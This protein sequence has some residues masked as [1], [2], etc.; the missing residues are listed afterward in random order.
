MVRMTEQ[1]VGVVP[2]FTI[3]DRL[4]KAR[5]LTGLDQ[6]QFALAL[7]VSR[8]TVSNYEGGAT[9]HLKP[10]VLKQWALY[11]GVSLE[12]IETGITSE[13]TG[14]DGDGGADDRVRT[15]NHLLAMRRVQRD[16]R[17]LSDVADAA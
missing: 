7:G 2:E 4:R 12:W 14:P 13:P 1:P 9:T 16:V 8:G 3:G 11:A 5:E 15:G 17:Y 6:E 10:I